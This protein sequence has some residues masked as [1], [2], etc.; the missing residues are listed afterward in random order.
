ML[1]WY[2]SHNVQVV[3]FSL[4]G[5]ICLDLSAIYP[6]IATGRSADDMHCSVESFPG[7]LRYLVNYNQ[8]ARQAISTCQVCNGI[9]SKD[10]KRK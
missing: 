5:Q 9:N 1:G 4:S 8:Q 2:S 10:L 6:I 7:M 3:Y